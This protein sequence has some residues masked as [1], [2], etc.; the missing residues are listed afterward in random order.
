MVTKVRDIYITCERGLEAVT[1]LAVEAVNEMMDCFPKY[2]SLYP[3]TNLQ[4]WK[5]SNFLHQENGEIFLSPYESIDWY[6]EGAKLRAEQDG[7]WSTRKQISIDQLLED[8]L[9]DPYREKY[10]QLSILL[11]KEDL[12]GSVGNGRLLNFCLGVN[13]Q[14]CCIISTAR[15]LDSNNCLKKEEFKTVLMH[16]FGHAIGLTPE[17]RKNST[18]NLGTHCLDE[19][20]VMQQRANGDFSDITYVRLKAKGYGLPPICDD[21]IEAG[22]AYF[23]KELRKVQLQETM[24]WLKGNQR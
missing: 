5:S 23:Q 24:Q 4:N 11:V 21:C 16:E 19:Y 13:N 14:G 15:F 7:R 1:P 12:Y 3:V 22:N 6:I 9:K 10:P 17:G 18:E 20:C 2:K 8:L